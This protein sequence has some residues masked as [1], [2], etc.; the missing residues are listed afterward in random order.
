M[1]VCVFY[2]PLRS[3][4]AIFTFP[5]ITQCTTRAKQFPLAISD[6]FPDPSYH[7]PPPLFLDTFPFV[8]CGGNV[9]RDS[10]QKWDRC[11]LPKHNG[12]GEH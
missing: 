1:C 7:T 4:L 8:V 11:N 3:S 9:D 12:W 10:H 2:I 5:S 6:L